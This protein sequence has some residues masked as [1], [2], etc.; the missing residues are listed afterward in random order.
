MPNW[1]NTLTVISAPK[2]VLD[3]FIADGKKPSKDKQI[4]GCEYTFESWVPMP[5]TFKNYDTTNHPFGKNIKE[6][7]RKCKDTKVLYKGEMVLVTEEN[8]DQIVKSYK[9]ASRHQSKKYGV[10]GWYDFGCQYWGTKWNTGLDLE[11]VSDT[12]VQIRTTTAWNSPDEF[13]M[14][15]GKLYPE[16]EIHMRAHDEFPWNKEV[17]IHG[18]ETIVDDVD[19]TE[20]QAFIAKEIDKLEF[21]EEIKA[22]YLQCLNE[23]ISGE[24]WDCTIEPVD[25]WTSFNDWYVED[26]V[27]SAVTV[28]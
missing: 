9:R 2:E 5:K 6:A 24:V 22:K 8:V 16:M 15:I 17:F 21:S 4:D 20:V 10:V 1:T 28:E 26:V 18:D 12:E 27:E 19:A 7:F 3:K 13:F 11:R 25:N 23:F 14:K